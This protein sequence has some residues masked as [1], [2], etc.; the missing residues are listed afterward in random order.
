MAEFTAVYD[1]LKIILKLNGDQN[2]GLSSELF[3][4]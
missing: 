2:S 4:G 3:Q 1:V